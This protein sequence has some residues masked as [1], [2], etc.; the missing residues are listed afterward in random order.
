MEIL[1]EEVRTHFPCQVSSILKFL[2]FHQTTAL[3]RFAIELLIQ[4]VEGDVGL[5]TLLDAPNQ[6]LELCL[7]SSQRT[8][9]VYHIPFAWRKCEIKAIAEPGNDGCAPAGY[10]CVHAKKA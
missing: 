1:R 10:G 4:G 2:T 9:I 8:P 6:F 5:R 7:F 3:Q